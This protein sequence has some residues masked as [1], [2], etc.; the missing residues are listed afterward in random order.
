MKETCQWCYRA[1]LDPEK[2]KKTC[3]LDPG[4]PTAKRLQSKYHNRYMEQN[5]AQLVGAKLL[6][7]KSV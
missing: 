1:I 5:N 2:H 3:T 4:S 6:S 7:S